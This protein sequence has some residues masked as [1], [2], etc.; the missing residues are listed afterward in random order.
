M[1]SRA[2][3]RPLPTAQAPSA[4]KDRLPDKRA[5]TGAAFCTP[6]GGSFPTRKPSPSRISFEPPV[7]GV[8]TN[9]N[10]TEYSFRALRSAATRQGGAP[11]IGIQA[12]SKGN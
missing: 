6:T 4:M 10:E 11:G 12:E 9:E 5:V 8:D 7:H 1:T 2:T 3:S